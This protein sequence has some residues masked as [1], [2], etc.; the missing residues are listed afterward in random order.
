MALLTLDT[1]LDGV[2]CQELPL[3]VFLA[4]CSELQRMISFLTP[5]SS[6]GGG[7]IFAWNTLARGI[8]ALEAT[9]DDLQTATLQEALLRAGSKEA[10]SRARSAVQGIA[11]VLQFVSAFLLELTSASSNHASKK[12]A[13][14]ASR[15]DELRSVLLSAYH[16][17]FG[18]MH[19]WIVQK[20]VT[21]A[22]SASSPTRSTFF[23][24]LRHGNERVVRSDRILERA[25]RTCGMQLKVTHAHT[26]HCSRSCLPSSERLTLPCCCLVVVRLCMCSS[27]SR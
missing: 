1:S 17:V 3:L 6:P 2:S 18:P 19:P 14:D 23:A 15:D 9:E 24:A 26:W 25:L 20:T 21:E 11:H 5:V 7:L 4:V 27:L 12:S 22:I 8:A 10:E 16:H 13:A